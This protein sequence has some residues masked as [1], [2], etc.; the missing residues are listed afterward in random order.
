MTEL[1]VLANP[2]FSILT[3]PSNDYP[4]KT[5]YAPQHN[6]Q[7]YHDETGNVVKFY[8]LNEAYRYIQAHEQEF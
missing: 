3:F 8:D 1:Y 5:V 2:Q 4:G 7:F 6:E